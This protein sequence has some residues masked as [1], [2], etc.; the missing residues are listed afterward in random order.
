M[1]KIYLIALAFITI[2]SHLNAQVIFNETFETY[3]LGDMLN[4]NTEL[5]GVWSGNNNAAEDIDISDAYANSGTKSGF[6]GPGQGPQDVLLNLGNKTTGVYQLTF[7][8]FIPTGKT[9]YFNIQGML[10]ASGGA[11]NGGNGIF[12]S[13]NLVFNNTQNPAGGPGIGGAYPG[14]NTGDANYVWDYP[15]AAWFPIVITF[16]P[17]SSQW[18]MSVNNVEIPRQNMDEDM[19]VGGI[20]FF[21]I[22]ANNEYYIDDLVFTEGDLTDVKN[23]EAKVLSVYPNPVVN[24][25]FIQTEEEVNEIVVYDILGQLIMRK[26]VNIISPS[27]NLSDLR[28]GTYLLRIVVGDKT[29]AIKITK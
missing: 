24:E 25:L 29:K 14:I 11:G 5:W 12:N 28:S 16:Y 21:A 1:K 27:I 3:D 6:I 19:V 13:T 2:A 15:E 20:D 26:Q 8:M 17:D 22:D 7:Q 18:Q 10:S 4:Q 9:A 23:Q